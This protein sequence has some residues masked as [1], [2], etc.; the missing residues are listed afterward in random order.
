MNKFIIWL[1]D[2][3]TQWL[4]LKALP[5]TKAIVKLTLVFNIIL[6]VL[7]WVIFL[8]INQIMK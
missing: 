6:Q 1:S 2:I 7:G 8:I 5:M 3:L 4:N